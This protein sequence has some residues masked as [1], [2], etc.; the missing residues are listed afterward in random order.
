[1]F[2]LE[3]AGVPRPVQQVIV[4]ATAYEPDDRLAEAGSLA[5]S[6]QGLIENLADSPRTTSAAPD[7]PSEIAD[8]DR[9]AP[10]M[11]SSQPSEPT[12]IR[13]D[14]AVKAN[15]ARCPYCH[16]AVRPG[17]DEPKP[18]AYMVTKTPEPN[19]PMDPSKGV[20]DFTIYAISETY[21]GMEGC[22]AH[23]DVASTMG[24]QTDD[25][26]ILPRFMDMMKNY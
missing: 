1:M 26:P 9:G 11:K 19:D 4:Q 24:A 15:H 21:A 23:M 2:A 17:P 8:R 6:L 3:R 20:T 5:Q 18:L 12:P 10:V 16:E 25:S 22:M 13:D 14:L 7:R